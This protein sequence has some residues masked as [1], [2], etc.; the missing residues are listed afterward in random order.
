MCTEGI[1]E[2]GFLLIATTV[3]TYRNYSVAAQYDDVVRARLYARIANY[4]PNLLALNILRIASMRAA[5]HTCLC[6][7]LPSTRTMERQK[8]DRH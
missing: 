2:S 3:P 7:V 1:I 8:L 4:L 5:Y 6:M